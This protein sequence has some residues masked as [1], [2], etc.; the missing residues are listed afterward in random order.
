MKKANFKD[1]GQTYKGYIIVDSVSSL[2]DFMHEVHYGMVKESATE[3]V[4]RDK[5]RLK[6]GFSPHP[7]DVLVYGAETVTKLI[8]RGCLYNQAVLAGSVQTE[9]VRLVESGK[10]IAINPFNKISYFAI[11]DGVE[12]EHIEVD[13]Y[14]KDDI[15]VSRYPDGVHWYAKVGLID[16]VVDGNVKWN[17]KWV[18]QQKAE[19]FLEE[20][21]K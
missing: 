7:T 8:G 21:Y 2:I 11:S 4:N 14:T 3:L 20:Y 13:K 5:T 12:L 17:A 6:G 15:H 16:V 18:A 19:E 9:W 1:N 10:R